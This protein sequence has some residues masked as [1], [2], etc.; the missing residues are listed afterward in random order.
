M[1]DIDLDGAFYSADKWVEAFNANIDLKELEEYNLS[2]PSKGIKK[3]RYKR[4]YMDIDI[5]KTIGSVLSVFILGCSFL[6]YFLGNI[7]LDT[8]LII[9]VLSI[10]SI[11]REGYD[12]L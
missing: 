11:Y 3:I 4:G 10:I 12:K 9:S 7:S 1:K 6:S 8:L 2:K 5:Q